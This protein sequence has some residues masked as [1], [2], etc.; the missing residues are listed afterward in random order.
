MINRQGFTEKD[1]RLFSGRISEWRES[2]MNR[3]IQDYVALL[4]GNAS[5]MDKFH[6]LERRMRED[7]K[8]AD[9]PLRMS[10][11]NML[12]NMAALIDKGIISRSEL[13]LFS[14]ELQE[15]MKFMLGDSQ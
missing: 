13:A 1:W 8:K 14:D 3:A 6:D 2:F 5:A 11:S 10:R 9:V 4:N 15:T 12:L 7:R